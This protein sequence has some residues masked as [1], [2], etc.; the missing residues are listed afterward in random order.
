VQQGD[1]V[2]EARTEAA[3]RLRRERDLGHEHDHAL[4]ALEGRRRGAQVDLGLAGAGDPVQEPLAAALDR[5]HRGLLL[6]AQLHAVVG[7]VGGMR[8]APVRTRRDRHE[9]A[10]FQPPQRA[11]LGAREPG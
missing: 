6:H 2:T 1:R 9:A 5:G 3:D 11:E 7:D 8:R 10:G 4:P